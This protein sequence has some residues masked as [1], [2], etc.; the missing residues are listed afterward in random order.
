MTQL[1]PVMKAK[2]IFERIG[3]NDRLMRRAAEVFRHKDGMTGGDLD[4]WLQ[5]EQE[6]LWKPSIELRQKD[7]EFRLE[8]AVPGLEARDLDIK[9]TP[10]DILVRA[11]VHHVHNEDCGEVYACEF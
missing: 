10:E 11:G 2:S 4:D 9:A 5:A 6:S 7:D 1:V 8:I 3:F